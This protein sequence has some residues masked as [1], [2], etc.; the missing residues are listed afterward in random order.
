LGI[1]LN[2]FRRRHWTRTSRNAHTKVS[3]CKW[4]G[5]GKHMLVPIQNAR[6]GISSDLRYRWYGRVFY[7][8]Q[9]TQLYKTL[10]HLYELESV[11][12][13][14]YTCPE[15][16]K[17]MRGN[18]TY[19]TPSTTQSIFLQHCLALALPSRWCSAASL[20]LFGIVTTSRHPW[21]ERNK[22]PLASEP[23]FASLF[24]TKRVALLARRIPMTGGLISA[25]HAFLS[26]I[27][28]KD[29]VL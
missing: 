11:V 16:E 29:R 26:R 7:K 22:L 6:L 15:I 3:D 28:L 18:L 10:G 23:P 4:S 5:S 27:P 25:G 17:R 2:K 20:C 13:C 9:E 12:T 14:R 1:V 8:T 21:S 19:P 24:R